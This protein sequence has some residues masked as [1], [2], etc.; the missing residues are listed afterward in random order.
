MKSYV[1]GFRIISSGDKHQ[2][3]ID[4]ESSDVKLSFSIKV[5]GTRNDAIKLS[6]HLMDEAVNYCED[7]RDFLDRKKSE[8]F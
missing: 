5:D 8:L 7:Y 2:I 1:T 4:A 6:E 3:M